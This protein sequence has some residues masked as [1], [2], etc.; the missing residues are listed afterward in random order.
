M[1][2]QFTLPNV[3]TYF[4]LMIV[5]VALAMPTCAAEKRYVLQLKEHNERAL[6]INSH[7]R[8]TAEH[9]LQTYQYFTMEGVNDVLSLDFKLTIYAADVDYYLCFHQG[10]LVGKRNATK[11]CHFKEGMINGYYH[12]TSYYKPKLRVGFK[13]KFKPVGLKDFAKPRVMDKAIFFFYRLGEEEIPETLANGSNSNSLKS[14]NQ[15]NSNNNNNNNNE[16]DL[17]QQQVILQ[18]NRLQHRRLQPKKRQQQQ[19]QKQQQQQQQHHRRRHRQRGTVRHHHDNATIM[20]RRRRRR[21]ERQQHKLQRELWEQ[22]QRE[23]GELERERERLEHLPKATSSASSSSS[24]SSTATSTALTATAASA[25][26]ISQ[27]GNIYGNV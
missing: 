22:K 25:N 26:I 7:G 8:V 18:R 16:V 20:E 14:Y 10:R 11:D 19:Q 24:S 17:E 27:S 2:L 3:R 4:I 9:I 6:H 23:A 15:A 13:A 1:L 21:L 5:V 12:Y